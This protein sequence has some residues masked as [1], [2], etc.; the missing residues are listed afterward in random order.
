MDDAHSC[1][2]EPN[3]NRHMK[4]NFLCN[5]LA[6]GLVAQVAL[7]APQPEQPATADAAARAADSN[8]RSTDERHPARSVV[9]GPPLSLYHGEVQV[10]DLADVSRIAVGN[11]DVLR[12]NVVASNQVVLIGQAAGTTSLRVWTRNGSQFTYEV[13]VR[14]FDVAQILRDVQDLLAGEPGISARQVDGHVLIEGDYTAARTASRLEALMKIYPQ[15]ISTVAIHKDAPAVPQERMVYM[16]VRVVEM[17]KST[18]RQLGVNWVSGANESSAG[19]SLNLNLSGS[20][21][22]LKVPNGG[23]FG[24]A[25]NLSSVLDYTER[26]GESWTLAEPSVSCKSGGS[27]KFQVGGEIPIYVAGG[28]GTVNVVYKEYGVILEFK[29][30]ADDKGNISSSIVAEVSEPDSKFSNVGGNGLVAFTKTRT[31]TDVSLKENQTLVI[32]GLLSDVGNRAATGIPGAKDIPVLGNLFKS[33][34]FQN[35]RTELVVLVTPHSMAVGNELNAA[36]IRRADEI[37]TQLAPTI[38][39]INSRLVE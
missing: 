31:E 28:L 11:G 8:T 32:S 35:D 34:Q 16:D 25:T 27:A 5:L 10:L 14:A 6:L 30:V 1:H 21:N 12:A 36:S 19:P 18:V 37:N 33:R 39:Y 23:V 3:E 38:K 22:M 2:I 20:K 26:A 17:L 13:N 9:N 29:P 7:A 4:P 15:I 24:I